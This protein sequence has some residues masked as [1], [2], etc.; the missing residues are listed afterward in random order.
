MTQEELKNLIGYK[1]DRLIILNQ[2]KQTLVD[3]DN[4]ISI[5]K[6]M[7]SFRT[8]YYSSKRFLLLLILTKKFTTYDLRQNW[9]SIY[10][11]F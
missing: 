9:S 11:S 7:R 2:K 1:E 3:L 4:E 8:I 6:F 10:T 5:S